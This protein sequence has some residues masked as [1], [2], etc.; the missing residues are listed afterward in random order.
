MTQQQYHNKRDCNCQNG[1]M[2]TSIN[3]NAPTNNYVYRNLPPPPPK[4]K[5]NNNKK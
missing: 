5:N 3:I 4:K 1:D 2:L